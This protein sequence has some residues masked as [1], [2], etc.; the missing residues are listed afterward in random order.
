MAEM[1]ST[2]SETVNHDGDG[3]VSAHVGASGFRAEVRAR[4]HVLTAD[5]PANLGG[6]DA[7]PTPYEL[8]LGALSSC[9]AM[10]L[11]IYADRKRW[12]LESAVVQLRAA[13][14][15]EI[16]CEHCETEPVGIGRI[17][18]RVEL[19]GPL[20]DEQRTRLL[21]IADRCPVKQTLERGMK[22]V[23]AP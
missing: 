19:A 13:R 18:R 20:T 8:L 11:R 7:G 2:K 15:H 4:A 3:W 1:T 22:I 5:E 9:T 10:T 14:S 12:P 23:S 6:T 21:E 16:D 17:E